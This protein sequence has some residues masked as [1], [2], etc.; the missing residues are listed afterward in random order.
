MHIANKG[1]TFRCFHS[2]SILVWF[3]LQKFTGFFRSC[4]VS[5]ACKRWHVCKQRGIRDCMESRRMKQLQLRNSVFRSHCLVPWPLGHQNHRH[6]N[7]VRP[8][9]QH[10]FDIYRWLD[11]PCTRLYIPKAVGLV[12]RALAFLLPLHLLW[13]WQCRIR[14]EMWKWSNWIHSTI[15]IFDFES[16]RTYWLPFFHSK[17]SSSSN[18]QMASTLA[19]QNL[20]NDLEKWNR[21]N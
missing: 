13:Y 9:A 17:N 1:H 10:K 6:K 15:S 14:L 3:Q 18:H 4:Q 7:R 8:H 2:N 5:I 20:S 16:F 11:C 19:S 12:S 21:S